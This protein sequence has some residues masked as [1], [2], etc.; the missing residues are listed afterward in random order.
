[1]TAYSQSAVEHRLRQLVAGA[2]HT[3]TL[4]QPR[5]EFVEVWNRLSKVPTWVNR[6]ERQLIKIGARIESGCP[7]HSDYERMERLARK[8]ERLDL[9]LAKWDDV[10]EQQVRAWR[11]E[12]AG[13]RIRSSCSH[14]SA[15]SGRARCF[16]PRSRAVTHRR[17]R[18][19][20]SLARSR[21][22][23]DDGG[24]PPRSRALAEVPRLIGGAS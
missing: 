18:S 1:M 5:L 20:A 21:G 4:S 22:N 14:S 2:R 7:R 6:V 17:R 19:A 13:F 8:I 9:R 15:R 23:D 10:I 24:E 3:S 11:A 16:R 12:A